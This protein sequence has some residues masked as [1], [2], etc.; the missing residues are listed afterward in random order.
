MYIKGL[1]YVYTMDGQEKK[2]LHIVISDE[3]LEGI[4]RAV[5]LGY[6]M[7]RSNFVRA[8]IGNTLKD[9][10]IITEMK[11]KKRK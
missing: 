4:D 10:S 7:N 8:A 5:E 1:W 3:M 6:S 2:T 9:L 11:Q